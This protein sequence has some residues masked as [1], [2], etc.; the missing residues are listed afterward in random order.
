MTARPL[1]TPTFGPVVA[2]DRATRVFRRGPET[3]V[4]VDNAD[5]AIDAGTVTVIAGPSGSGKTTLLNL[6]IGWDRPDTGHRRPRTASVDWAELA[7]IPQRLGLLDDCTIIENIELPTRV[8]PGSIDPTVIATALGLDHLTHRFPPETSLGEQ[9]R[10]AVARALVTS[11]ALLVA[12]EPSSHQDDVNTA[13][14][15]SQF[16]RAAAA[17]TAVVIATHD[18]RIAQH[19]DR[20]WTIIDGVLSPMSD[21]RVH[22]SP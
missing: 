14:I 5:I 7:V 10:T 16:E 17:G 3:I 8:R 4:A 9:Q 2:L 1:R 19:A 18:H 6:L 11:P 12:D 20:R 13:R 21:G 15:I 22:S